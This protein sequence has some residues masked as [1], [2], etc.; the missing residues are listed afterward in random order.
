[1]E[2]LA[3]SALVAIALLVVELVDF[4]RGR[5]LDHSDGNARAEPTLESLSREP[6]VEPVAAG[7]D[8]DD[9]DRAA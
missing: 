6:T 1:M 8:T 3:A 7:S 2:L 4:L 5:T 9:L